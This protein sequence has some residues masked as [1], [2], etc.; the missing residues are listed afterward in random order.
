MSRKLETLIGGVFIMVLIFAAP[1]ARTQ[2]IK[3]KAAACASCHGEDGIPRDKT[4]PVIWGQHQ[5]YLYLQLRDF[6]RG[7]RKSDAMAPFVEQMERDDMM[8]LAEYFSKK[9]WPDLRQPRAPAS[10]VTQAQRT[11]TSVGCTGCHQAQYQG[12]GTQP[13]L[14]GQFKEYLIKSMMNFRTRERA[15]NPGM[16]DLMIATA[17]DDLAAMAEYLAGLRLN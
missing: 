13:R 3:D 10:V 12:E 16:S 8:A 5:G 11:K 9:P 4:L 7:T 6:K 15:N 2:T 1:L 17:P 14:A